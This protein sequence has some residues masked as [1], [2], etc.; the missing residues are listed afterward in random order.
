MNLQ[1]LYVA[2]VQIDPDLWLIIGAS[3]AVKNV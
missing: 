3:L 1:I 2:H